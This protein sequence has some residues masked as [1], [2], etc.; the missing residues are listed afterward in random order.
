MRLWCVDS[1]HVPS[2][3]IYPSHMGYVFLKCIF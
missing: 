2:S 1:G 3:H